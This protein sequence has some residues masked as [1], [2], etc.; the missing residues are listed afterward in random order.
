[1]CVT[2]RSF[3]KPMILWLLLLLILLL[4]TKLYDV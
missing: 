1:V 4:L 2:G 3:V